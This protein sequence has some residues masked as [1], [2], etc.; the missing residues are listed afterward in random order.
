MKTS[1]ASKPV[2]T[3]IVTL[4]LP[5]TTIMGIH[6]Y[7]ESPSDDVEQKG[8]LRAPAAL[9]EAGIPCVVFGED[10]LSI[11]YC[12]PTMCFDLHLLVRE[13]DLAS[14]VT[15]ICNSLPYRLSLEDNTGKWR[16]SRVESLDRPHAFALN[17]S[18]VFLTLTDPSFDEVSH[19]GVLLF[20]MDAQKLTQFSAG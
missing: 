10:A 13:A 19:H 12:V 1:L 3:H 18:T 11:I 15:A 5:P 17:E 6:F 14:A 7:T 20:S 16:D 8:R 9:L 2:F 4:T